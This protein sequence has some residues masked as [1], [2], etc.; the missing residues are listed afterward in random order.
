MQTIDD[1]RGHLFATLDGLRDKKEP[2]DIDRAKAVAEVAGKI[3][4]SAKVEC[5]HMKLTGQQGSGFIP[6]EPPKQGQPR[7]IRGSASR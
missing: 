1:L 6:V 7:L 3:I 4:E 5:E 2:M